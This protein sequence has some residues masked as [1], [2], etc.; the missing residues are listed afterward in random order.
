MA[1]EYGNIGLIL[2]EK[3]DFDKALE[4]HN[5]A[6]KLYHETKNAEG[7]AREYGNIGLI[8]REKGDFDKALEYHNNALELYHETKNAEGIETKKAARQYS[9][10]R[11]SRKVDELLNS[12]KI[13]PY[14]DVNALN[15]KG[16]DL[17]Y[18]SK[19]YEAIK[20]FDRSLEIDPKSAPSLF[21]KGYA[22]YSLEKYDEALECFDKARELNPELESS[23]VIKGESTSSILELGYRILLSPIAKRM[24]TK[25]EKLSSSME[26]LRIIMPLK[27][28]LQSITMPLK[29]ALQSGH[30]PLKSPNM[31][32]KYVIYPGIYH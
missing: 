15:N 18:E 11:L 4:Y 25:G 30:M 10:N 16:L 26:I 27:Y 7:M 9:V 8:L 20:Y 21:N 23:S 19:Q 13:D 5:N 6:L 24:R 17:Y 22:L 29:Y 14:N 32:L 3:G 12:L 1:R 31:P 28:P 2:R